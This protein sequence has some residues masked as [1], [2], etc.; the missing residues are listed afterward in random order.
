MGRTGGH[1]KCRA[2]S[3]TDRR[4]SSI[5][6]ST[7]FGI[8]VWGAGQGQFHI[9]GHGL[10]RLDG[11]IRR[12]TGTLKPV[13]PPDRTLVSAKHEGL[14]GENQRL[15]SQNC[16]MHDSNCVHGMEGELFGSAHFS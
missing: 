9:P 4:P 10:Y 2:F 6:A 7:K 12:E 5:F 14:D 11:L 13:S 1:A 8:W 3:A 16:S 15:N